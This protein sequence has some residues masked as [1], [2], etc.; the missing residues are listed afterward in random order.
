MLIIFFFH[1]ILLSLLDQDYITWYR[2]NKIQIINLQS[3]SKNM[4]YGK[5]KLRDIKLKGS[6]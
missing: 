3:N 5:D 4:D 1:K 2:K 6:K